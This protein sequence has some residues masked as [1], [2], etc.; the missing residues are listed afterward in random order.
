MNNMEIE[1][2][3]CPYGTG[4]IREILTSMQS[5]EECLWRMTRTIYDIVKAHGGDINIKTVN[6]ERLSAEASAEAGSKFI[7]QLPII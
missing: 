7:I 3:T 1:N 2:R 5:P 6:N 4:S